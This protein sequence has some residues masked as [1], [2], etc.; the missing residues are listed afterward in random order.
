MSDVSFAR[1]RTI[2]SALGRVDGSVMRT[3]RRPWFDRP[4]LFPDPVPMFESTASMCGFFRTIA[5]TRFWYSTIPSND[6]PCAASVEARMRPVS[7]DGRKPLGT[8]RKR[9][10]VAISVAS[11]KAMT[12]GRCRIAQ[13][14][15]RS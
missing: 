13:C 14:S 4:T 11:E 2:S 15:V 8:A 7:S 12:Y 6:V 1:M 5:A 3:V 10:T 9:K